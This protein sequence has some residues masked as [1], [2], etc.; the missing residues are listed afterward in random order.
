MDVTRITIY[1]GKGKL[2]YEIK[3]PD[4]I[5]SFSSNWK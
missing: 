1:I 2:I 3:M 4:E 5:D